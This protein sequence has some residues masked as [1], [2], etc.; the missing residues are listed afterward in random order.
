MSAL[1]KR[2]LLRVAIAEKLAI[3]LEIHKLQRAQRHKK[4]FWYRQIHREQEGK[5]G[6]NLLVREMMQHD[7][8]FLFSLTGCPQLHT[9]SF[10]RSFDHKT[11]H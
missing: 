5:G 6:C 7:A 8:E 3:L 1:S 11:M 9:N 10:N 2:S 4:R